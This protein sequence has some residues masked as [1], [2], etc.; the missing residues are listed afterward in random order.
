MYSYH[1]NTTLAHGD[2]LS[3]N[4]IP[5]SSALSD[6]DF[7]TVT[8]PYSLIPDPQ[9][10]TLIASSLTP[11]APTSW[12][13][14]AG[15]WGDQAYPSSDPRQYRIFSEKAYSSGPL[16]PRFKAL[17]RHTVCPHASDC[18]IRDSIEPRWAL[19]LFFDWLAAAGIVWISVGLGL[20]IRNCWR[21]SGCRCFG[22]S[23][24]EKERRRDRKGKGKW[25]EDVD[26]VVDVEEALRERE[27]DPLLRDMDE[28]SNFWARG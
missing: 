17:G 27:R 1:Y 22:T 10:E 4:S 5:P 18:E 21:A 7:S 15:H 28:A 25:T 20:A 9:A 14:F 23:E 13:Y 6:A 3:I 26:D 8:Y 24:A 11:D 19:R 16:G 12:F 2:D